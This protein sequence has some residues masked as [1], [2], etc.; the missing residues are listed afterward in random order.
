MSSPGDGWLFDAPPCRFIIIIMRA[1]SMLLLSCSLDISSN[2]ITRRLWLTTAGLFR[3][4]SVG[5]TAFV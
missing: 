5:L 4:T 2:I 1:N 3:A